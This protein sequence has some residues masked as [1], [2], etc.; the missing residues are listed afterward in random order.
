V[1]FC[2]KH[3]PKGSPTNAEPNTIEM[4]AA[5]NMTSV[6]GCEAETSIPTTFT[7]T[8]TPGDPCEVHVSANHESQ[9]LKDMVAEASNHGLAL[10]ANGYMPAFECGGVATSSENVPI[11]FDGDAVV[12][13]TNAARRVTI[14]R[15]SDMVQWKPLLTVVASDTFQVIDTT[16]QTQTFYRVK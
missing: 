13:A 5:R 14:E 6:D 16:A 7:L 8:V 9:D 11:K 1:R 3:F 10:S 4:G 12:I 2:Q 15:S